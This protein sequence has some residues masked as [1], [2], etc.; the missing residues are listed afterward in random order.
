M[1]H[2][3]GFLTA[4]PPI[5]LASSFLRL[6]ACGQHFQGS[7]A[8]AANA[9]SGSQ[10]PDT[11][12]GTHHTLSQCTAQGRLPHGDGRPDNDGAQFG[13]RPRRVIKWGK[14]ALALHHSE[15]GET[16]ILDLRSFHRSWRY[17]LGISFMLLLLVQLALFAPAVRLNA[18]VAYGVNGTV[19]DSSGAVIPGA[20]VDA[21]RRGNRSCHTRCLFTCGCFYHRALQPRRLL[22]HG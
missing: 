20:Q 18:Q 11:L 14:S 16:V 15:G 22:G 10:V 1:G 19:T 21:A 4:C 8:G 6:P 17:E 2:R 13:G 7:I 9:P 3:L 5:F 12:S